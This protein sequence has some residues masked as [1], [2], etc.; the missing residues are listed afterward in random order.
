M[1]KR[2]QKGKSI[3][4]GTRRAV[5]AYVLGDDFDEIEIVEDQSGQ[6]SLL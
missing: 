6:M 2:A 4:P 5:S 3:L 1:L